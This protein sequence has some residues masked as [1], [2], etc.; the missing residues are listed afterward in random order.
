MQGD[1]GGVELHRHRERAERTLDRDPEQGGDGPHRRCADA[2]P[3]HLHDDEHG[4][5]KHDHADRRRRVAMRHLDPGLCVRHCT[6][7]HRRFSQSDGFARAGRT[8]VAVAARPIGTAEAG[9][10]E[11]REGADENQVEAEKERE[12]RERAQA[13]CRRRVAASRPEPEQRADREHQAHCGDAEQGRQVVSGLWAVHRPGRS[14][15]AEARSS[16]STSRFNFAG[17]ASGGA[18]IIQSPCGST[19]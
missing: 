13:R 11:P 8:R 2:A 19:M 15:P 4:E 17:S 7:R 3:T 18:R 1:D 6:R 14:Q 12:Q 16:F 9:I 5:G 10:A